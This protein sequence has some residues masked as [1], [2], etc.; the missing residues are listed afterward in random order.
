MGAV[1]IGSFEN[2][3]ALDW[4]DAFCDDPDIDTI[5]AAF[6][7]VV[8]LGPGESVENTDCGAAIA[9]AEVVAALRG[10][11]SPDLPEELER[12]IGENRSRVLVTEELAELARRAL[13]RIRHDSDMNDGWI[14]EPTRL[15][16][17]AHLN[18]LETRLVRQEP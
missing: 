6:E 15:Q 17:R 18:E 16:W 8:A 12:W 14:D 1:G 11:P 3:D 9:A 4:V 2:D 7:A 5:T 10:S 13:S